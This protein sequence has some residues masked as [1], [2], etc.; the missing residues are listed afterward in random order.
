MNRQTE[1]LK[2]KQNLFAPY[3]LQGNLSVPL[4]PIQ[5]QTVQILISNRIEQGNLLRY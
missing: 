5:P 1:E 4:K 3:P 2:D